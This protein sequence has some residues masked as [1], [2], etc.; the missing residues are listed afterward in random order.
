VPQGWIQRSTSGFD[1]TIFQLVAPST[2]LN[3]PTTIDIASL[4]QDIPYKSPMD[5]ITGITQVNYTLVGQI[6]TCI[7]GGDSAAY[8][9]YTLGSRA[10]YMVLWVHLSVAYSLIL[11]GTGGLDPKAIQDAKGVLGSLSWTS[12]TPPPNYT[13]SGSPA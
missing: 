9:Q 8:T 1:A 4:F 5:L 13:P 10:G 12:N 6:Q 7:I 2:Y 11:E 3:A